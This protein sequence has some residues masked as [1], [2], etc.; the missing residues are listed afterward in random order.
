M[1]QT[2]ADTLVGVLERIG[3]KQ[4]FALIGDSLNP[5]ADSPR[6]SSIDWIGVRHEEGAALAASGQAKL[7]SRLAVCAGAAGPGSTH[8]V[9]G[10]YEAARDHAPV[11][12]LS[13]KMPRKMQG[14]DY[15]Q[16]TNPDL[17]F[18]DVSLYTE[19]INSPEQAPAVIH[20]AIAA[21]YAGRGV[22]RL[23]LPQDIIL[24]GTNG[25]VAS[26]D[27][28]R[29]IG[30]VCHDRSRKSRLGAR[31]GKIAARRPNHCS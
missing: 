25:G 27:T 30:S 2:A 28:P 11:L 15:I 23:T 26:M 13:G 12:A 9:A 20:Q 24:A 29:R 16:T 5:L 4:I 8:L 10:L 17:L 6:S 19:T 18:R 1:A 3:V 14:V 31:R 7:T 22:A 21:A